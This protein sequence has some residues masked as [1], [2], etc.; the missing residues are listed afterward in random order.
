MASIFYVF[1]LVL[2]SDYL[3]IDFG[4]MLCIEKFIAFTVPYYLTFVTN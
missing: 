4:F 2:F 3:N 1:K